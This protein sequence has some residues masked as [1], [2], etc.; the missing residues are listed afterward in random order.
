MNTST[1]LLSFIIPVFNIE[2]YI[3]NCVNSILGQVG[4]DCEVILIDD[5]STDR[6]ESFVIVYHH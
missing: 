5:G 1:V 4:Q 3:E 6:V 2:K